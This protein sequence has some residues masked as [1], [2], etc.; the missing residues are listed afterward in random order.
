MLNLKVENQFTG[1][2]AHKGTLRHLEEAVKKSSTLEEVAL[3][4]QE[5]GLGTY[6]GGHHVAIHPIY[7]GQFAGGS[8]RLA[9]ITEISD[10]SGLSPCQ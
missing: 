9:I 1:P 4:A 7:N 3:L 10:I 5:I 6:R 2:L 8:E